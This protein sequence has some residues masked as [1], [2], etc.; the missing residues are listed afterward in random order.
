MLSVHHTPRFVDLMKAMRDI[1]LVNRRK[2]GGYT[3]YDIVDSKNPQAKQSVAVM[4]N[5]RGNPSVD[6]ATRENQLGVQGFR[7]VMRMVGKLHPE[8]KTM[9]INRDKAAVR[10]AYKMPGIPPYDDTKP[11]TER[12]KDLQDGLN[13]IRQEKARATESMR[14][15]GINPKQQKAHRNPYANPG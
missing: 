3:S 13:M 15:R 11:E 1:A 2:E 6:I 14:Q 5:R 10:A 8:M 9:R 4:A 7:A 12:M